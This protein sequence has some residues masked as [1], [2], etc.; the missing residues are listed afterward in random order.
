MSS[1]SPPVSPSPSPSPANMDNNSTIPTTPNSPKSVQ[2]DFDN[3]R[4]VTDAEID[5]LC[6]KKTITPVDPSTP[7]SLPDLLPAPTT[8]PAEGT[9]IVD[10]PMFKRN[11]VLREDEKIFRR[12]HVIGHVFNLIQPIL[13]ITTPYPDDGPYFIFSEAGAPIAYRLTIPVLWSFVD[14]FKE[15]EDHKFLSRHL[16]TITHY[17]GLANMIN[18][19]LDHPYCLA[20]IPILQE[21]GTVEHVG[22]HGTPGIN[23][24]GLE[25]DRNFEYPRFTNPD[26]DRRR[27]DRGPRP[28]HHSDHRRQ[29]NTRPMRLGPEPAPIRQPPPSRNLSNSSNSLLRLFGTNAAACESFNQQAVTIIG[30]GL[31]QMN[32]K[33]QN[34]VNN[35]RRR[36]D[37][38]RASAFRAGRR[39]YHYN[40]QG[41]HNHGQGSHNHGNGYHNH[42]DH[43]DQ[44][45]RDRDVHR[46]DNHRDHRDEAPRVRDSHRYDNHSSRRREASQA[47]VAGPSSDAMDLDP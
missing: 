1:P 15:I 6:S 27:V 14:A 12:A 43:R 30:S 5:E 40:N 19:A 45:P 23:Y 39:G 22:V 21:D 18:R 32:L 37:R 20:R 33:L 29:T 44:A 24:F 35:L 11:L 7:S 8:T 46:Y 42:R 3:P 47:P 31:Q 2:I 36:S 17:N 34:Q 28:V 41:Y 26:T 9:S 10:V 13:V 25:V 38:E 4:P 16:E